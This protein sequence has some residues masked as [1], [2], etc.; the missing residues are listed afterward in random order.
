MSGPTGSQKLAVLLCKFKGTD[1]DEPNPRGFYED[2]FR[3]GTGGFN[4]YWSAAS[5]GNINLDGSEVFGWR[6]LDQTAA[7]YRASHV[8]RWDKIQGALDAF[9][10]VDVDKYFGVVAMFNS[11]VR[12][13]GRSGVGVLANY[14]SH[15]STF[16]AHETGHL[17]G[18]GHSFDQSD[19]T[20]RQDSA[21]GEYYDNHDIMSAM[22]VYHHT[23]PRFGPSGP[24]LC[25]PFMDYMRWLDP[26][27]VWTP[28]HAGSTAETLEL[29][30]LG[31]PETRGYLAAKVDDSLYVEFRTKDGWDEG[32]PRATVLIHELVGR[33]VV[34][35]TTKTG[36]WYVVSGGWE[37]E[38]LPGELFG[39]TPVVMEVAGGTQ[40][41]V[42]S[43]DLPAGK[44]LIR[45]RRRA[46]RPAAKHGQIL[47]G[48][49]GGGGG[50]LILP[51][52]RVVKVP[53]RSPVIG[54]LFSLTALAA[55]VRERFAALR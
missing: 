34:A 8:G 13:R 48:V 24:L 20:W 3:R 44:A 17:F 16:L 26:K 22:R 25:A 40:V 41:A 42:E 1:H 37:H 43:F 38:W 7:E 33:T 49:A 6:T 35:M 21:P 14:D 5:H 51:N 12:D 29:T 18:L 53:P 30:S 15:N 39:P 19:R 54:A 32:L 31:H 10:E 47:A 28:P 45:I 2:L 23:H 36:G 11:D 55:R 27:R 9:P 46:P 4:D 50:I 52:G